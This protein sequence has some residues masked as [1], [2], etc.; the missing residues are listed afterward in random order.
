MEI[1]IL[2]YNLF[3]NK[4]V[5]DLIY[6]LKK[7]QPDIVGLQEVQI[8][9]NLQK[10]FKNIGYTIGASSHS[11][12]KFGIEYKILTLYNTKKVK[13]SKFNYLNLPRN[14]YEKLL[15]VLRKSPLPRSFTLSFFSKAGKEFAH[16]NVHLSPWSTDGAKVKQIRKLF[17]STKKIKVP[18]VISGD[19]NF[20]Y[21]RRRFEFLLQQYNL[22]EATKDL[23]YTQESRI[24]K[25]LPIRLKLD[26]ILFKNLKHIQTKRLSKLTSDH[27]PIL[28]SFYL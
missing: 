10:A 8:K 21:G 4:A 17:E 3:F 19:F 12:T 5:E 1:K 13:F 22:N 20:P 6:I 9:N 27:Y 26:Y 7:Y 18:F 23:F 11:F 24:L 14:M 16:I 25:I 28:S 15:Y 2:S